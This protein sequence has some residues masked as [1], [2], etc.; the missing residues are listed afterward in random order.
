MGCAGSKDT[1]VGGP[2]GSFKVKFKK[3]PLKG[4]KS[5][6]TEQFA[7]MLEGMA[8]KPIEDQLWTEANIHEHRAM[9]VGMMAMFAGDYNAE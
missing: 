2:P 7:K 5:P 9:N 8:S 3:L 1:S 4:E 6:E